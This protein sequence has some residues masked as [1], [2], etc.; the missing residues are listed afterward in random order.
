MANLSTASPPPAVSPGN[1]LFISPHGEELIR[2]E[3]HGMEYL[4]AHARQLAAACTLAAPTGPARPLLRRFAENGQVL[5]RAYR[6]ITQATRRQEAITPDT[7]WLL[8]NFFIVEDV[9]REVKHDLPR[10]YYTKLPR[11][12]RG[13]MAGYPRV[14]ALALALV[15]HTD[16]SLDEVHILRF[17]QAYQTVAP[18][19]IGE[20]WAVP[21]MLRLAVIENLRR[22]AEQ[23]LRAWEDR[24]HAESWAASN[25]P[26]PGPGAEPTP[27]GQPPTF[28]SGPPPRLN[29]P[30]I[31]HLLE[32]LRRHESIVS[33]GIEWL[34]RHLGAGGTS[35]AEVVR[36]ESQRQASNQVT[37]G[38][39][40]TSLRLLSALDWNVFF[41][42]VSLVETLLGEDPCGAYNRQDFATRDRYRQEVEK[43][44]RGSKWLEP[45]V[46]RRAVELARRGDAA[47]RRRSETAGHPISLP[48]E[49][50]VGYYLT[51]QGRRELE[52]VIEYRP[53]ASDRL[54][55]FLIDR[56]NAVYF[57][58]IGGLS[59]LILAAILA[60]AWN[61][62]ARWMLL[63]VLAATLVPASEL[64][65]GVVN[66]FIT[67][68]LPPRTLPKLDFKKGI[69]A[70]N[71]A[72]V[73]MP[74][75]LAAQR[76]GGDA[77]GDGWRFITWQIPIRTCVSPC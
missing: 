45:D 36:R 41:E 49:N 46:A 2:G 65:V 1:Q 6:E 37:I 64:A 20:L 61:A 58:A 68:L 76:G 72:F 9:L 57:G 74:S 63:V 60:T 51:D 8:D 35:C 25:L 31:V 10:G 4:E 29:D 69:G 32:A 42:K 3:L 59:L 77:A 47:L 53:K 67:L 33:T 21:T 26:V 18:L 55:R 5:V 15:A 39:C 62:G 66:Y 70:G 75:M 7:E 50:H 52:R 19:T 43:L 44:S 27:N 34:E 22:L 48:A 14:Y 73:A 12:D 40:V 28:C 24:R 17:V 13:P 38:N 54:V 11:L 30:F 71:A 56:A 16:S 23:M